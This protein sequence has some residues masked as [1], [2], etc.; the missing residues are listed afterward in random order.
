MSKIIDCG[1]YTLERIF[2]KFQMGEVYR[3]NNGS[4]YELLAITP[5]G[6]TFRQ[7]DS[8]WTVRAIGTQMFV[9]TDKATGES[10]RVIEWAHGLE[11]RFED[12]S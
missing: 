1:K 4:D 12:A 2:W 5:E 3:N 11:G 6:L 7:V 9:R 10:Y 8:G